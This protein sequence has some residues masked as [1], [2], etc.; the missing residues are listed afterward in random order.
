MAALPSI[1]DF[2]NLVASKCIFLCILFCFLA[3]FTD[4]RPDAKKVLV[5]IID[6]KSDN[7]EEEVRQAAVSLE[8][9][10]IRVIPVALGREADIPE[11]AN[12]TL[13][14]DDVVK[15]DREDDPEK[16]ADEI[17]MKA[18]EFVFHY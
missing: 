3:H 14:K 10:K 2:I 15:A 4:L 16:I 9:D 6:N 17:I 1:D 18:S 8:N 11:L 13:D 12:A 7:A 5:I